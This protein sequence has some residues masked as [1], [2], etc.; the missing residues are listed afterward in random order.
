MTD[1]RCRAMSDEVALVFQG[2]PS[3]ARETVSEIRELIFSVADSTDGV[4]PLTECLKWGEPAYLTEK[5]KSGSTIRLGWKS[6]EPEI[7]MMHFICHS[8]L[9][10]TFW[11]RFEDVLEFR[12]N[13]SI[14]LQAGEALPEDYLRACIAL[15]LTWHL[16]KKSERRPS[17]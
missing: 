2:F 3:P 17:V 10:D 7:C 8:G 16:R 1:S 12:G 4:G 14:V 13:R 11:E 5:T 6:A 15:A 9:I